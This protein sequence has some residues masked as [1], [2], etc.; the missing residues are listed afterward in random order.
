VA[1]QFELDIAKFVAAAKGDLNFVVRRV[2][3]DMF[4]RVVNKSPVD[5]GR[6]KSSFVVGINSIPTEDPG[7]LDKEAAIRRINATV[8]QMKVG[9]Q[10]T[11]M[12]NL[13]Y[14]NR[15]EFGHSQQAPGGMVRLTAIEFGAVTK[16]AEAGVPPK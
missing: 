12:S 10:I 14:A 13:A 5:T 11:L 6:F 1:T 8:P 4:K 9:D 3:L 7:T 2:S 16:A 15:L